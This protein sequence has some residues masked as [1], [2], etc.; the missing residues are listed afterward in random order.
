MDNKQQQ[1]GD[2]DYNS[3]QREL[4]GDCGAKQAEA[5]G[6]L[7]P[8]LCFFFTFNILIL[9]K[10]T[11]VVALPSTPIPSECKPKISFFKILRFSSWFYNA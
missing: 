6:A 5:G 10:Y 9:S 3:G 8:T 7:C 4:G 1:A 11:R 2:A